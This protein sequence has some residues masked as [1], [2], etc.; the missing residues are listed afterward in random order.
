VG[1][2][3]LVDLHGYSYSAPTAL[4]SLMS[5]LNPRP[6]LRGDPGLRIWRPERDSPYVFQCFFSIHGIE[7][8]IRK[9]NKWNAEQ[10][11]YPAKEKWM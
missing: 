11:I 5:S 8:T 3:R 9:G 7:N 10:E 6:P 4:P 2:D 1:K